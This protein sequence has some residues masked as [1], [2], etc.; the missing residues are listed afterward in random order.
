MTA[1]EVENSLLDWQNVCLNM[2]KNLGELE[3]GTAYDLVKT[4]ELKGESKVCAEKIKAAI[5]RLR[6]LYGLLAAALADA[7]K[8]HAELP[9]WGS[10]RTKCLARIA[11][12]LVGQSVLLEVEQIELSKRRFGGDSSREVR[13][14]MNELRE[15]MNSFFQTAAS[16]LEK[17]WGSWTKHSRMLAELQQRALALREE[18]K[19][20]SVEPEAIT[21]LIA[22][23]E[24]TDKRRK[25]NPLS[26]DQLDMESAFHSYFEDAKRAL[27]DFETMKV[28]LRQSLKKAHHSLEQLK[29]IRVEALRFHKQAES[30]FGRQSSQLKV[31]E[32]TR[33]FVDYL[34][35]MTELEQA[36]RWSDL[37]QKLADW[38]KMFEA[39]LA[40][41]LTVREHNSGLLVKV[42]ALKRRRTQLVYQAESRKVEIKGS[43]KAFLAKADE[44]LVAPVALSEVERYLDS[45][46]TKLNEIIA[47]Q[48]A[49]K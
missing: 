21:A 19:V 46:D 15:E 10:S 8:Q 38:S 40:K 41:M 49:A 29:Q 2:L 32:G 25:S 14:S 27:R 43:L 12:I 13:I 6:Y 30:H 16:L 24:S 4:V 34:T 42:E 37:K 20:M 36:E 5:K 39:G 35:A 31:P 23:I 7:E 48:P 9:G 17:L 22:R 45:F 26:L 3:S 33:Q 28:N 11:E 18:A 1:E 47:R 44:H